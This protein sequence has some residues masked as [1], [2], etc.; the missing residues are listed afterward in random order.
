MTTDTTTRRGRRPAGERA[1]SQAERDAKYR[2]SK[3]GRLERLAERWA[4]APAEVGRQVLALLGKRTPAQPAAE[5]AEDAVT[6]TGHE[7]NPDVFHGRLGNRAF[8]SIIRLSRGGPHFWSV[9]ERLP[10][11]QT[12]PLGRGEQLDVESAKRAAEAA[13]RRA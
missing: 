10:D 6:W 7:C 3:R 5:Q 13:M 1:M 12:R 11:G 9:C 2:A 4:D 8:A